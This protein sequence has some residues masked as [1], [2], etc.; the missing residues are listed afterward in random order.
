M[1]ARSEYQYCKSCCTVTE[2]V[3]NEDQEVWICIILGCYKIKG[4]PKYLR[5]QDQL[6]C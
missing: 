5:K 2:H 3:F 6:N 1:G 4:T